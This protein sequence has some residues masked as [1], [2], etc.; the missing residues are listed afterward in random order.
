MRFYR[1]ANLSKQEGLWYD[2]E[3]KFTGLIHDKFSFC[4]NSTLAMDFDEALIGYLSATPSLESLYT[5]F[6]KEDIMALQEHGYVVCIYEA[7]DHFFYDKFQH[8]VI[9]Q[10][11]SVLIDKIVL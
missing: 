9:N 8:Y 2:F 1:L 4:A 5:W 7:D 6:P 11:T 3:G 10:Q